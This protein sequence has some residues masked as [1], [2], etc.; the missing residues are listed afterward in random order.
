MNYLKHKS[1]YDIYRLYYDRID[2]SGGNNVNKTSKSKKCDWYFL[3]KDFNFQ[4]HVYNGYHNLLMI[5]MNISD[6]A[7]LNI[8]SADYCCIISRISNSESKN[9]MQNIDLTEKSWTL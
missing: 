4:T 7:I 2:A 8:K 1:L 5:S 9:L 3:H 6:I